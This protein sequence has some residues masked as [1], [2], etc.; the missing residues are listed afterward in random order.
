MLK[1]NKNFMYLGVALLLGV[2]AAIAA[3]S[4]IR[5]EVEARA[6]TVDQPMTAVAVPVTDLAAGTVIDSEQMLAVREIPADMVPAE[7]VTP[8]NYTSMMGRMLRAPVRAG[9]PFSSAVLVPVYDQF[10]SVIQAGS[11]GYTLTVDQTNSIS[12]MVTP[13]DHIDILL[14]VDQGDKGT[15]VMPLLEDILVLATGTR[16]GDSPLMENEAG[17]STVTLELEPPQAERLAVAD[18]AGDLRVILRQR[19][20]REDFQ[21]SGL[22]ERDLLRTGGGPAAGV[23]FIIGGN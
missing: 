5:S 11:V 18:K 22:T 4:Y 19:H 7:A 16:I 12:G 15:R 10:S 2:I 1:V 9:A 3:V 21:L 14:T 8:D 17:Y 20:D 6:V 23:E 13:G